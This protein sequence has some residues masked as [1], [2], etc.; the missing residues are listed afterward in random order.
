MGRH[1]LKK[2]LKRKRREK[3]H[4]KFYRH[5]LLRKI[6]ALES[7]PLGIIKTLKESFERFQ[8]QKHQTH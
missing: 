7:P 1:G 2:Y 6:W 5:I 4:L 8:M 3:Q